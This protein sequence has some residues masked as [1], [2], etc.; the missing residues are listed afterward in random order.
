VSG[1][2]AVTTAK[3]ERFIR[4]HAPATPFLVV[5]L[6]VVEQQYL[7]LR[8]QLATAEIFY[9]VKANPAPEIISRLIGLGSSFDVASPSE[10]E[11]LLSLGADPARLSYGN[12]IKKRRDIAFAYQ[13]GVDL[14]AFDSEGELDK[15]VAVAPDARVFCR[16][17]VSN[18][19]AE[20]PLSRKFGCEPEMAKALLRQARDRGL[21]PYGLAFHVGSQQRCVEQ[22][23]TAVEICARIFRELEADGIEL[24][25]LDVGGGLPARYDSGVAGVGAYTDAIS[26]SLHR[27]FGNRLP[28][29]IVEPG[30]YLVGDAGVLQSEVVLVSRKSYDDDTRWVYLDVGR[31]GGLAETEGEMIRYPITTSRD[32]GDDGPVV[33]AGPTCDSVDIL[34]ERAG[35]R[36]P[37]DL[38]PGDTVRFHATGAYT[39]TYSSV[40]FNGFDPLP[41][42]YV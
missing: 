3:I 26:E 4:E 2:P 5:D 14:F 7:A 11:L 39:T 9:A 25:M 41:A 22:W 33:I 32:G 30:R 35:Y 36:L 6:D 20:W 8:A 29:T 34:Y 37:L 1:A 42:Y 28:R 40:G 38:A 21:T 16:L 24:A 23:D 12:T 19:G 27:H 18:S 15:L 10:V 17:L 31:F 13:R